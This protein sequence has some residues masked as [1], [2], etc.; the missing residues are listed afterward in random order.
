MYIMSCKL[1]CDAKS[2]VECNVKCNA[3]IFQDARLH[4]VYAI[5]CHA[6]ESVMYI[7]LIVMLFEGM[8]N[9]VTY[10]VPF[11]AIFNAMHNL[12]CI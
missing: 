2:N 11:N 12:E 10:C 3:K 1:N 4:P 5:V 6:T 9:D 7:F 8:A